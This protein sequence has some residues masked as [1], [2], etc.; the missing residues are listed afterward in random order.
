MTKRMKTLL[1]PLLILVLVVSMLSACVKGAGDITTNGTATEVITTTQKAEGSLDELIKLSYFGYWCG[2]ILDDNFCEKII[3]DAL[4]IELETKKVNH[5]KKEQIDL[6][7]ASGDMPDMGWFDGNYPPAYM[8]DDQQLTRLIPL[9]MIKMYAPSFIKTYDNFPILYNQVASKEDINQHYALSGHQAFMAGKQYFFSS[10]YR[11]D[12]LDKFGIVPST[13]VEKV[14]DGVYITEKGFTLDQFEEILYKFTKEDPDENGKDDTVGMIGCKSFV[15]D[16]SPLLG[17]FGLVTDFT[18]NDNGN[19]VYYYSSEKYK[20]FLKFVH[21]M[22]GQGYIDKEIF[23]LD[24]QQFWE[25]AQRGYG[26]YFGVSANWLGSWASARPPLNIINN[27]DGASV[28]MT[29]GE[30][31]SDGSMGTR[32]YAPTP[33][34]GW[35]YVNKNITDNDKLIRILQFAE[36]TGFGENMMEL[37]FGE[38]NV[39]YKI[40]DG[41]PVR[42]DGFVAGGNRGIQSY[43]LFVQ[44]EEYLKL[45][46]DKMFI[47]TQKYTL[48]KD[49]LWNK[50]LVMPYRY[51]LK[52]ETKLSEYNTKYNSNIKDIVDEFFASAV[53][54][55]VDIDTG[56]DTYI[57]KLN[58]AGYDKIIEELNKAPLYSDLIKNN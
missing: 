50:F 11:K 58:A 5:A 30:I 9:D 25:K 27:I 15:F 28:L 34:Y 19:A 49:G 55:E 43:S 6:M 42:N 24:N 47:A 4:N 29:P 13:P 32:M 12:W 54:G 53:I 8:Y 41:V 17:A 52:N 2:E 7:F 31:G 1:V 33:Q 45:I 21:R 18:L 46:N 26:G 35:F 20:E 44:T 40:T 57:K 23:I 39:D 3:Q 38:E 14:V 36:Y 10:F 37:S 48:G 16:W 56:W 22:Y 51:D